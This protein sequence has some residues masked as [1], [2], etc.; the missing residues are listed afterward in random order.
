M[1]S[2]WR[3]GRILHTMKLDVE[4]NEAF[5]LSIGEARA[6]SGAGA[7]SIANQKHLPSTDDKDRK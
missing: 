4:R 3:E 6:A 2:P 1:P 7:R 5:S